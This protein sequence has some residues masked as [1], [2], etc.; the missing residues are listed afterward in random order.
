MSFLVAAEKFPGLLWLEQRV[1]NQS[2]RPD[3]I[4]IVPIWIM[5]ASLIP[6]V[7]L[8]H[9]SHMEWKW[10][11][12][13]PKET[14]DT[15]ARMGGMTLG[16]QIN[17]QQPRL[18]SL[19]TNWEVWMVGNQ[20]LS[21]RIPYR[22]FSAGRPPLKS[23]SHLL[24][25]WSYFGLTSVFGKYPEGDYYIPMESRLRKGHGKTNPYQ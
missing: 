21:C 20:T 15:L 17:T 3:T 9:L 19:H 25:L 24:L 18:S 23:N 7:G 14:Q 13:I 10:V 16:M 6:G 4:S 8:V 12:S 5:S 11:E 22:R 2:P 1:M